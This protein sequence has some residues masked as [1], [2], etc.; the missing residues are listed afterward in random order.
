MDVQLNSLHQNTGISKNCDSG[1]R[2]LQTLEFGGDMLDLLWA[3]PI[4]KF[5]KS[6]TLWLVIVGIIICTGLE[7][8]RMLTQLK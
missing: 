3:R 6:I 5:N 2:Q 8:K 7:V 4:Y 1:T